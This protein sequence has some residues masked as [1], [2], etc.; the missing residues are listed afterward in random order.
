M[1]YQLS[2]LGGWYVWLYYIFWGYLKRLLYGLLLLV[3][4]PDMEP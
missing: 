4:R 1:L 2:Y 3:L